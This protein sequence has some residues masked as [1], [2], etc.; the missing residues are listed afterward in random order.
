M[1]RYRI[2]I[3]IKSDDFCHADE[4]SE[5]V[6]LTLEDYKNYISESLDYEIESCNQLEDDSIQ[7][8]KAQNGFDF[9]NRM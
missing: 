2:I 9:E 5:S 6:R 4:L 3:K 1:R 7:Q 8:K